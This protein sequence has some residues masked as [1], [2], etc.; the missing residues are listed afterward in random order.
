MHNSICFFPSKHFYGGK[1]QNVE[2]LQLLPAV[3]SVFSHPNER[4][5]WIDCDTPHRLGKVI[6]VGN[7]S[8]SFLGFSKVF[9]FSWDFRV[10]SDRFLIVLK[11]GK[12]F[13]IFGLDWQSHQRLFRKPKHDGPGEQH[14]DRKHR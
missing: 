1:L 2:N 12:V 4:V 6:Q 10:F 11:V 14:L 8:G 13:R 7:S 5:M 9:S 3:A